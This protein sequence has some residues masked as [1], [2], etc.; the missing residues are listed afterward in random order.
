MH[1]TLPMESISS[2]LKASTDDAI[3]VQNKKARVAAFVSPATSDGKESFE[4][5]IP[6]PKNKCMMM[7]TKPEA[8]EI[9]QRPKFNSKERRTVMKEMINQKW[10]PTS[11]PT[12][13]CLMKMAELGELVIDNS[14]SGNGHNGG[15]C[16]RMFGKEDVDELVGQWKRG[17][18]HGQ[19]SV[20]DAIMRVQAEVVARSGGVPINIGKEPSESTISRVTCAIANHHGVSISL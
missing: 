10:A 19:D 7:Y 1:V 9:I 12:L 3:I 2:C 18:A 6:S 13:S 14:W 16:K 4:F 5:Q 15:G 8:I 11:I 17:E 20:K